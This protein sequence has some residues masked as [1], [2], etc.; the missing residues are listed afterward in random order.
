MIRRPPRSTLF[1]YTTLFRSAVA[2]LFDH[3]LSQGA[4]GLHRG[5]V[6]ERRQRLQR[7]VG[8]HSPHG[9]ILTAGRVEGHHR[10]VGRGAAD[11]GVE[12]AAETV[13]ALAHCPSLAAVW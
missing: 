8:A 9:A 7:R 10:G 13:F 6:I 4:R 1:P 3:P 5:F 11:E 12:A 2:A